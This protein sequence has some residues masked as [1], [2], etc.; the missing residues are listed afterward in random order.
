MSEN[1]SDTVWVSRAVACSPGGGG[2]RSGCGETCPQQR[3]GRSS[4]QGWEGS[5]EAP[6]VTWAGSLN[7]RA[8]WH[9]C[10]H[11][12]RPGASPQTEPSPPWLG[13]TLCARGWLG[14]G[15]SFP[16]AAGALLWQQEK[17]C[18]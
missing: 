13:S 15:G 4:C 7:S 1:T 9:V 5:E 3:F 11:V 2:G 12:C 16:S 18:C 6:A 10:A 14:H 17:G 8:E